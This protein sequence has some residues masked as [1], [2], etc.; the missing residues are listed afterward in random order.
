[1]DKKTLKEWRKEKGISAKEL[2]EKLGLSNVTIHHWENGTYELRQYMKMAIAYV[3]ELPDW[4]MIKDVEP[5]DILV[6]LKK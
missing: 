3:L 1:M 2:A 6:K 5:K 4:R